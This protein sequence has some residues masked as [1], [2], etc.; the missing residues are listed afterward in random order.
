MERKEAMEYLAW[1]D[2]PVVKELVGM[3]ICLI[4][5]PSLMFNAKCDEF[6]LHFKMREFIHQCPARYNEIISGHVVKGCM[7]S[8]NGEV[9][10]IADLV[11]DEY[12]VLDHIR[13]DSVGREV[14]TVSFSTRKLAEKLAEQELIIPKNISPDDELS[15]EMLRKDNE[16]VRTAAEIILERMN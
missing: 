13:E 10:F 2:V 16:A 5:R 11:E 7:D 3:G 1:R 14:H 12:I 15:R 4:D 8:Y 6:A 9:G